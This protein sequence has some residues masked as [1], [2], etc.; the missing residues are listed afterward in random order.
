MTRWYASGDGTFMETPYSV[1]FETSR[2]EYEKNEYT[3][4][5][6]RY[7]GVLMTSVLVAS[8]K[9]TSYDFGIGSWCTGSIERQFKIDKNEEVRDGTYFMVLTGKGIFGDRSTLARSPLFEMLRVFKPFGIDGQRTDLVERADLYYPRRSTDL[10]LDYQPRPLSLGFELRL[11]LFDA[12]YGVLIATSELVNSAYPATF[13]LGP[14]DDR[15]KY[16]TE[17]FIRRGWRTW[18]IV[19]RTPPKTIWDESIVW[20]D[21]GHRGLLLL[22]ED[23]NMYTSLPYQYT[24]DDYI[25]DLPNR[26]SFSE[27]TLNSV[28]CDNKF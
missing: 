18:Q 3:V 27:L 6:Y 14:I 20:T 5:L 10:I 15:K 9:F 8:Q 25:E 11:R 22:G 26:L 12:E 28:T 16:Y 13:T 21:E 7:R 1:R 17:L 4:T 24:P 19:Y 23:R 2:P